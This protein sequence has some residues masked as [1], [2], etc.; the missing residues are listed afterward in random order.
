MG[1]RRDCTT[2]PINRFAALLATLLSP[3][4]GLLA[5]TLLS[6]ECCLNECLWQVADVDLEKP[7]RKYL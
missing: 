6:E 4:V 5:R 7:T 3:V 2:S 1:L